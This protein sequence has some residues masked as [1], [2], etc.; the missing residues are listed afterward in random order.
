MY[1]T[2]RLLFS[3]I[4]RPLVASI[5]GPSSL[6]VDVNGTWT[7]SAIGGVGTK[8]YQWDYMWIC[9]GLSIQVEGCDT[10]NQGGTSSSWSKTVTGDLFDMKI[11]LTAT[12][13]DSNQ[14]IV[15]LIVDVYEP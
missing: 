8:T 15:Y 14:D 13:G 12:D 7:A 6:E 1:L 5:S 2:G 4:V 10:W 11:R 9:N 3:V